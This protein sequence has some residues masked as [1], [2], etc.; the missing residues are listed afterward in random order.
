MSTDYA[1]GVRPPYD[2]NQADQFEE[3]VSD[4]IQDARSALAND[5]PHLLHEIAKEAIDD[6]P[7]HAVWDGWK[8][9]NYGELVAEVY[10]TL[11]LELQKVWQR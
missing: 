1:F 4:A 9:D 7:V 6:Q 10:D 5:I 11:M 2:D 3:V 8:D